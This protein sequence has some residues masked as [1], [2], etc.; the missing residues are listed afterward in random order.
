MICNPYNPIL[1]PSAKSSLHKTLMTYGLRPKN[2]QKP[3]QMHSVYETV[4]VCSLSCALQYTELSPAVDNHTALGNTALPQTISSLLELAIDKTDRRAVP[5]PGR[6]N[7]VIELL[8]LGANLCMDHGKCLG[9]LTKP[10]AYPHQTRTELIS[11]KWDSP[12][13]SSRSSRAISKVSRLFP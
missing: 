11:L 12:K 5:S 8:R 6:V 9:I 3:S 4:Q 2:F 13:T 1:S 7:V 10:A